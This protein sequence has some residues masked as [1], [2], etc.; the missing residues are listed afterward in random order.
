MKLLP[1]QLAKY[2]VADVG[3]LYVPKDWYKIEWNHFND[4]STDVAFIQEHGDEWHIGSYSDWS[5]FVTEQELLDY[6]WIGT[7]PETIYVGSKHWEGE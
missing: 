4:F 1:E 7:V 5:T 6:I 3:R 2:F